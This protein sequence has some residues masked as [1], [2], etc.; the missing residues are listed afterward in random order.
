[1]VGVAVVLIFVFQVVVVVVP[2]IL[3]RGPCVPG[4]LHFGERQHCLAPGLLRGG[5][6]QR[7]APR[8]GTFDPVPVQA[9][10]GVL[11]VQQVHEPLRQVEV[12]ASVA[13][14]GWGGEVLGQ[15][16]RQL[17]DRADCLRRRLIAGQQVERERH[18]VS[19]PDRR[20]LTPA[21]GVERDEGQLLLGR[22]VGLAL[23]GVADD[24]FP[25]GV[26]RRQRHHQR[27]HHRVVL[28]RVLVREEELPLAVHQHRVRLGPQPCCRRQPQ[29]VPEVLQR[30]VHQ[31]RPA[32]SAE[33][34]LI[35]CDLPR[36]ADPGVGQRLLPAPEH[37]RP[38]R[39][40]QLLGLGRADR[41]AHWPDAGHLQPKEMRRGQQ[42]S[43]ERPAR[44]RVIEQPRQPFPCRLRH[45]T[46]PRL[47]SCVLCGPTVAPAGDL[48]GGGSLS[49][50]EVAEPGCRSR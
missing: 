16:V 36:V 49:A 48:Q 50:A 26:R 37:R 42:L 39:R 41:K 2:W 47:G 28:L 21:V 34:D 10:L 14:G 5:A 31:R 20:D 11:V 32:R 13:R 3:V 40:D 24:Q 29:F 4:L 46:P 19:G 17:G 23:P 25:A 18:P 12:P 45:A 27:A 30:A 15:A 1:L 43:A 6:Q 38:R 8:V 35:R 44:R 33:P 22:A 9:P 7:G